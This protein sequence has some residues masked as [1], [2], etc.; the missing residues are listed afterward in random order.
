MID[1]VQIVNVPV[2][3]QQAAYEYYVDRLGLEV[4][5]DMEAGPHGRWLQV[6]PA[7]ASTTLALTP[8]ED[9]AAGSIDGLVFETA[10]ID[11]AVDALE[12]QGV[13]FANGIEDQP[14][15]RVA[16]FQDPDGNQ[17]ALQTPL[18]DAV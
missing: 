4:V 15:A 7:G 5:A 18:A 8:A 16:R 11:A 13:D 9:A 3:D 17:L 10:D 2:S 1:A 12:A 14:W 6:A